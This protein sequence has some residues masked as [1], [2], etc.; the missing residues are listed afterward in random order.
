MEHLNALI[1]Q[2]QQKLD[3]LDRAYLK[4][5]VLLNQVQQKTNVK[6]SHQV[7]IGATF[8]LLLLLT[9]GSNTVGM[10]VGF[11]Y[12]AYRSFKAIESG[13]KDDNTQWLMYWVVYS[14]VVI[15]AFTDMLF[16][17][18]PFYT[19][20]KLGLLIYMMKYDGGRV[21]YKNLCAPYLRKSEDKIEAL[22]TK[23]SE[24]VEEVQ[25]S[26]AAAAV[27]EPEQHERASTG[28]SP[29]T[30]TPAEPIPAHVP[31]TKPAEAPAPVTDND[32]I[33]E[34]ENK[35]TRVYDGVDDMMRAV[36]RLSEDPAV[37]EAGMRSREKCLHWLGRIGGKY[38]YFWYL[39]VSHASEF[40]GDPAEE[41]IR[42]LRLN[43]A[44]VDDFSTPVNQLVAPCLGYPRE[45]EALTFCLLYVDRSMCARY[46]TPRPRPMASAL[47]LIPPHPGDT[48][49][50][51][52]TRLMSPRTMIAVLDYVKEEGFMISYVSLIG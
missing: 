14:F 30:E 51:W 48:T 47:E 35:Q 24:V 11:V 20:L 15:E 1:K 4:D 12:P 38:G 9:V 22:L 32:P 52:L 2:L 37:V 31:P 7:A 13:D 10:L 26:G 6:R 3:E 16:W 19:W 17:I 21:I 45:R 41:Y 18:V 8:L 46:R 23:A 49:L 43:G 44:D 5:V 42:R 25:K 34:E 40:L 29:A 28:S 39:V 36:K 33:H 27:A 50:M